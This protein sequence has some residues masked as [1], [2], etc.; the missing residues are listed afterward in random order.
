MVRERSYICDEDVEHP[1]PLVQNLQPEWCF[2]AE[3]AAKRDNHFTYLNITIVP[4]GLK[5]G[6]LRW[7]SICT[8]LGSSPKT[9]P[10]IECVCV[11]AMC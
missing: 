6:K 2:Q 11:R 10:E 5:A 3:T 7:L 4:S 9:D 8:K 1:T